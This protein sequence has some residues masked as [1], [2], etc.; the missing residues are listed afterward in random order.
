MSTS[1]T[2]HPS[3][4]SNQYMDKVRGSPTQNQRGGANGRKRLKTPRSPD[5]LKVR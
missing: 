5:S 3:S 2:P 4:W 1:L